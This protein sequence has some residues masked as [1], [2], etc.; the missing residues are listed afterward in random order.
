MK[1]LVGFVHP[2]LLPDAIKAARAAGVGAAFDNSSSS[3]S[4]SS[5]SVGAG[6]AKSSYLLQSATN[7]R[8]FFLFQLEARVRQ[9]AAVC[10]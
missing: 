10:S 2:A 3:S 9:L 6:G 1:D 8:R 5:S 7:S 4:S